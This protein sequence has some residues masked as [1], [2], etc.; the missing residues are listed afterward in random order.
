MHVVVVTENVPNTKYG[1]GAITA[2][3][4][5]DSLRMRGYKVTVLSLRDTL[6]DNAEVVEWL[7]ALETVGVDVVTIATQ[8]VISSNASYRS[9]LH[10]LLMLLRPRLED[11]YPTVRL[12]DRVREILKQL[13]PD[14]VFAY[15]W[16]STAATHGL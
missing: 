13:A 12:K 5:I 3:S 7:R 6:G 9:R 14:A 4:V 1:G 11:L 16:L 2:W 8:D 10:T 15:H